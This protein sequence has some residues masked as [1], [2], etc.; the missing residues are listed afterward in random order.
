[1]AAASPASLPFS[2]A[3]ENNKIPILAVLRRHLGQPALVLEIGS[4]TGQHAAFFSSEL[5]HLT[6][7][8]TDVAEHLPGIAA[9]RSHGGGPGLRAPRALDV[10][11]RPWLDAGVDAVFSANTAHIMSWEEVQVFF[12]GV[13]EVL[14][15]GGLLLL[16]GPF[17]YGG[18]AT[19]PSNAEFDLWLRRRDPHSGVRHFEEVDALAAAV[20]LRLREDNSMPA[21]NRLLVWQLD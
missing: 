11:D 14:R 5:P 1:M 13:A 7:Q 17:H 21:N 15:P 6:W 2:Q 3:C 16:Y 10:R 12:A 19:S 8:P 20:G 4:G 18:A 9:W